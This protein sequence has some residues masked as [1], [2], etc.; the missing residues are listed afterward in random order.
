LNLNLLSELNRSGL[1]PAIPSEFCMWPPYLEKQKPL[2]IR[3]ER[4]SQ[5]LPFISV[6]ASGDKIKVRI[7]GVS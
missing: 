1:I 4:Q 2:H 3:A 6:N 5:T 7:R